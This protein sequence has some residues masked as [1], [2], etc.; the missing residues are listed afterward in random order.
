MTRAI[1][2][3]IRVGTNESSVLGD[4]LKKEQDVDILILYEK[5]VL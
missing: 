2:D 3:T 1:L 5:N 4:Q